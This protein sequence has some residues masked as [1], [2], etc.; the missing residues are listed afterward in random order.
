M[1]I[2]VYTGNTQYS[3]LELKQAI[4]NAWKKMIPF[5]LSKLANS[6]TSYQ[7]GFKG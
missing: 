4:M 1:A 6:V 7:S 2:D 3:T 5:T